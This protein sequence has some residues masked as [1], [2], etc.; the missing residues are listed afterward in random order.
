MNIIDSSLNKIKLDGYF[1]S[2]AY[3][4]YTI[5]TLLAVSELNI[6]RINSVSILRYILSILIET[7][8]IITKNVKGHPELFKILIRLSA[9]I[10]TCD[11]KIQLLTDDYNKVC[12]F[13][14]ECVSERL[15]IPKNGLMDYQIDLYKNICP[16]EYFK[17]LNDI[18]LDSSDPLT[19]KNTFLWMTKYDSDFDYT[20][21]K[22]ILSKQTIVNNIDYY[23]NKKCDTYINHLISRR[24]RKIL[25]YNDFKTILNSILE[26]Q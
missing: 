5:N 21:V 19:V 18:L 22:K 7:G 12:M 6:N 14:E 1:N 16:N 23:L 20:I 8:D 9:L 3:D 4:P 13:V 25:L 11:D 2:K 17:K 15:Y 26:N 24:Q 10:D